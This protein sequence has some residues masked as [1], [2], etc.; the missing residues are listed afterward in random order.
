[1]GAATGQTGFLA[2]YDQPAL[3]GFQL[4]VEELNAEGGID[5]AVQIEVEVKD[6]RSDAGQTAVAAQEL[7]D[8][9]VDV[10]IL[11]C[12][13]DPAI[14]GGQLAQKAQIPAFSFC[15]TTPT[16]TTAVGDFMFGNYPPDNV[17]AWAVANHAYEAGLRNA[18]LLG[19]PDQLYTEALPK[20][21]E[22]TFTGLGGTIVGSGTFKSDQQDFGSEITKIKGLDP[23]PD[24]IYTS[25]FEPVFPAFIKQLRAAGVDI[26]VFGADALDTATTPTLGAL[27]DGTVYATAGFAEPGSELEAFYEKMTAEYGQ[28]NAIIYAAA[29]YNLARVLAAA[30][31]QAGGTDPVA[32]RDAIANLKDVQGVTGPITYAGTEGTPIER[33]PIT[34]IYVVTLQDGVASLLEQATPDP[35]EVPSLP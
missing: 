31:E 4:G 3:Q 17:N 19:S 18:Y 1:V 10:L 7:L 35:T 2:P 8:A 20:Y 26:P 16:L 11:P 30:V 25:A 32:L 27:V 23:Q 24:V 15:A 29:G 6:T 13:A 34:G 28:E 12:D 9:G 33:F 14:A 5:G 22:Q 21:F